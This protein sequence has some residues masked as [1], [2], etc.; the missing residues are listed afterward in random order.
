MAN[1]ANLLFI[2]PPWLGAGHS[3]SN[4]RKNLICDAKE[5]RGASKVRILPFK[6]CW[7]SVVSKLVGEDSLTGFL[8]V[9]ASNGACW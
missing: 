7:K 1:M 4:Q 2:E 6:I 3:G 5:G 8:F 9:Y